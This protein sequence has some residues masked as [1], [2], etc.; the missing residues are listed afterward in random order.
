D[1][2]AVAAIDDVDLRVGVDV[3][4]EPHAARAEDAAVPVQH[5]RRT[6]IDVGLDA[7]AV[8][9]APREF[10]P[11][12]VGSE[13]IGKILKR[14]L[15]ALVAHRAIERMIDQ[16]ELEHSRARDDD[17]RRAR[18]HDHPFGAD[19]RTR[20]LQLRH[21]LDLDDA[22]AAGA[23]DADTGVVAVVRHRDAG[24]DRRLQD[25]F[26]LLDGHARAVNRQCHRFHKHQ[27][28]NDR[29]LNL[30]NT[31]WGAYI[32]PYTPWKLHG[33]GRV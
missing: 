18:A 9:F 22:D 11:A 23:V 26:A 29:A 14:T 30:D 19:R 24:L 3:A 5:Q 10:H 20:R 28:Y 8:E 1:L 6:E 12:L 27:E 17:L 31:G 2:A 21:L 7:V 32:P 25:R 15:A 16:Q 33:R 13:R 4:H